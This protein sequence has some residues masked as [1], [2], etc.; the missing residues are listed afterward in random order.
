MQ[1]TIT[2]DRRELIGFNGLLAKFF[3]SLGHSLARY[4]VRQNL[5]RQFDLMSDR[6]LDDIG[7]GRGDVDAVIEGRHPRCTI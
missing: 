3:L 6:E 4:A 7:L 1:A 5:R 2:Y